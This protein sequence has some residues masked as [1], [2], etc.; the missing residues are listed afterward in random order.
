VAFAQ[1]EFLRMQRLHEQEQRRQPQQEQSVSDQVP[2]EAEV[3][4]VQ[5][6]DVDA[7]EAPAPQPDATTGT[8]YFLPLLVVFIAIV[9]GAYFGN[10][11]ISVSTAPVSPAEAEAE[12]VH[13]HRA[14]TLSE[15]NGMQASWAAVLNGSIHAVENELRGLPEFSLCRVPTELDF[16]QPLAQMTACPAEHL[17][18]DNAWND[19][20]QFKST[21]MNSERAVRAAS[22]TNSQSQ[23]PTASSIPDSLHS[24]PGLRE[25][26][27]TLDRYLLFLKLIFNHSLKC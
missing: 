10:N 20:L 25:A 14:V 17:K 11:P 12:D 23:T 18:I 22:N 15:Y 2:D 7:P 3:E 21:D 26:D 9:A 13:S 27:A 6:S 16:T 1:Q 24:L 19:W 4:P 5:S 8:S